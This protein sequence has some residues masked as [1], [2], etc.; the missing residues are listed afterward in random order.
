MV[1][2]PTR[3]GMLSERNGIA[4]GTLLALVLSALVVWLIVLMCVHVL[5]WQ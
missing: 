4:I 1:Y 2:S 5:G 3:N